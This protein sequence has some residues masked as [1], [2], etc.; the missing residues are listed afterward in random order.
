MTCQL[1]FLAEFQK[2]HLKADDMQGPINNNQFLNANK[3]F[4]FRHVSFHD[5]YKN[6]VRLAEHS[7]VG[8]HRKALF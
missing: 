7:R 4:L 3:S 5:H 1:R 6:G 2:L 8:Y